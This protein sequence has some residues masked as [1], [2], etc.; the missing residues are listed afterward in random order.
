MRRLLSFPCAGDTLAATLDEADGTP[1]ASGLLIVTGGTQVRVGAHLG[2]ARLARAAAAAGFAAFRF[3]RRGIGDSDGDDPG[4]RATGPDIAAAA[5]AFRAAAPGVRRIV[6]YGLCDAASALALHGGAAGLD[7][8]LLA[9]PWVVAPRDGL[10]PPAAIRRHYLAR[11]TSGA[12]WRRLLTDGIDLRKAARGLRAAATP[13]DAT[14]ADEMGAAIAAGVGAGLPI[15]FLLADADATAIAFAAEL[16]RPAY[17][18]ARTRP[19]DRL[20]TASHSFAGEAPGRWL[21]ER[22]IAALR[23]MDAAG[24]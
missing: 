1:A 21:A 2:Q 23:E 6:G 7:A 8:L 9:N 5:H 17:A 3:D 19:C 20:S 24:A 22:V 10:P 18:A 11:L 12:E 14:L 16:G 4:F 13:G 15:R